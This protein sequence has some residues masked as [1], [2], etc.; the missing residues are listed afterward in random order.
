MNDLTEYSE[1]EI[2]LAQRIYDAT[3]RASGDPTTR[4]SQNLAKKY[5]SPNIVKTPGPIYFETARMLLQQHEEERQKLIDA[6]FLGY[7]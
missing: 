4:Q 7:S 5:G 6:A 2:K 3:M 1:A